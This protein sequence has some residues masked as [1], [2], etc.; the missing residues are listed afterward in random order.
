MDFSTYI[1]FRAQSDMIFEGFIATL[2]IFGDN[3]AR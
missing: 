1:F 2:P 3:E